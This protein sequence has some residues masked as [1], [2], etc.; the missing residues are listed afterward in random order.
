[1][2]Q[3]KKKIDIGKRLMEMMIIPVA[4]AKMV[5]VLVMSSQNEII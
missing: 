3:Q 4:L 5:H 1:M 2:H